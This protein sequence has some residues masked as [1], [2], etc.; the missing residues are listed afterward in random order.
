MRYGWPRY[1][2]VAK[3]R[4]RAATELAK[5]AR[6]AGTSPVVIEGR[7]IA[8][9]FWGRSWCEAMESYGDYAN[10]LPRGRS[11]VR[12]G[13]VVDLRVEP[14]VI[15][16]KVSGTRLYTTTI[17]VQALA[18]AVW[19]AAV[20]RHAGQVA[21]L[22]DLL[23]G[24]L[25]A[26]LLQALADRSSG[27]FPGPKEL[28]FDC[29][30]PDWATMCKHVAA[31]L[32][33]V[34]ARLDE[35]PELFF[36]L[37]GVDVA[38]LVARSASV[39]F[40]GSGADELGGEDLGA[41]FGIELEEPVVAPKGAPKAA[42]AATVPPRAALAPVAARPVSMAAA[43]TPVAA[44]AAAKPAKVERTLAP[45]P[46]AAP[47]RRAAPVAREACIEVTAER[48]SGERQTL[49][50][51]GKDLVDAMASARAR[52]AGLPGGGWRVTNMVP[53]G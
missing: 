11:Y 45:A 37:R 15:H 10:R 13:A 1:V 39:G 35:A 2:P 9:S 49:R 7:T 4:A 50:V 43:P 26:S 27:L 6:G 40:A 12:S 32:Y 20:D 23:Q 52:V 36:R 14:G 8:R 31:V 24:K 38:D 48:G 47:R 53:V 25:P 29:S 28:S 17:T 41:M 44:P 51:L 18:P 16:A 19:R 21:S 3:R 42:P 22:V 46:V 33:G 30:C 34:G 5:G